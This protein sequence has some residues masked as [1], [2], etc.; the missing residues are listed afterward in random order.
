MSCDNLLDVTGETFVQVLHV[1]LLLLT[2]RFDGADAGA[3][4]Q[5]VGA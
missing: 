1:L 4:D 2:G 3:G 5:R